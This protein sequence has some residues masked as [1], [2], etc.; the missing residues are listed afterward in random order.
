MCAKPVL[1][2]LLHETLFEFERLAILS[3]NRGQVRAGMLLLLLLMMF[4]MMAMYTDAAIDNYK[5]TKGF[6]TLQ[7][8]V[9]IAAHFSLDCAE[10]APVRILFAAH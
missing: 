10:A 5:H 7:T 9:E 1:R 6:I 3:I 2:C 8:R 4:A